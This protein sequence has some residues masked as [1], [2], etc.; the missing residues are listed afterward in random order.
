MQLTKNKTIKLIKLGV[1]IWLVAS[2]QIFATATLSID[3]PLV[4]RI[5]EHPYPAIFQAWNP[6]EGTGKTPLEALALH[7]LVFGSVMFYHMKW[8]GDYDGMASS[9]SP[10]SEARGMAFRESVLG[11]NPNMVMLMEIRYR[12]APGKYLPKNSPFWK[13]DAAGHRIVGWAEGGYYKLDYTN[14]AFQDMVAS[15]AAAAVE[16]GVV[17]GI[18]LDWWH[19]NPARLTLIKKIREAVGKRALI[20]VNTNTE[21]APGSAKYI[22]GI[23]MECTAD[24][25]PGN[26]KQIANTLRW[27]EK[28]VRETRINCLETWWQHSRQDLNLMRA[29]TCLS[30]TM[31]NGYCLFCDPDPLPTPDHLHAWYP[32]WNYNLGKPLSNGVL[33]SDG[34]YTRRFENGEALYNPMGNGSQ[35]VKLGA[36]MWQVSTGKSVS[37]FVLPDED[38]EI[39]L[40]SSPQSS[41]ANS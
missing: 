15:Q 28:S 25:S 29:C 34:V 38:G 27:A 4:Q 6:A 33:G 8:A 23:Y 3:L 13:R 16:S 18:M 9:F 39:L 41:Q 17:D 30:L 12:D 20:L 21:T 1:I 11:L 36:P 5:N 22:N 24:N 26:W 37:T 35:T 19:E 14:P 2:I 32:F 10:G 40:N 31:S 7:N